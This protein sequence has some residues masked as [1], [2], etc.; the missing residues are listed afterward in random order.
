[1]MGKRGEITIFLSLVTVCCL[2]LFMGLLESART[3]GARL[4]LEMSVN[5]SMSSVMSQYNRNLWD[6]YHLLFLES[7]SEMAVKQSFEAFLEFYMKQENLYPM[8]LIETEMLDTVHM[9][10]HGGELLENEIAAYMRYRLPEVVTDMDV[11]AGAAREASRAGDFQQLFDVCLSAGTKTRKLE[12]SRIELE[13][14]LSGME[15]KLADAVEAAEE[16]ME[17]RLKNCLEEILDKAEQFPRL[18][19]AYE[20]ESERIS[21]YLE[22]LHKD[23]AAPDDVDA[24][25]KLNQ[26]IQ[27][28]AQVEGAAKEQLKQ[29]EEM[30]SQLESLKNQVKEILELLDA[31]TEHEEENGPDWSAIRGYLANM[32]IPEIVV[33]PK[34]EEKALAL[35]CLEELFS[36]GLSALVLPKNTEVSTKRVSMTGIPSREQGETDT[37]SR[38]LY[39][40]AYNHFV[41]NEYCLLSFDSFLE[42]KTT[43]PGREEQP[44]LYEM[45]YL[46][47]GKG[48]D[49]EN[50]TN[51]IQKLIFVRAAMN[52]CYLS[53]TPE[54]K[55]EADGFAAAISG[56]NIP[57]QVILSFFLL[58]L[59]SMGEAVLDVRALLAGGDVPFW[60]TMETW[61]LSL[62]QLV[63]LEFLNEVPYAGEK[64]TD[65]KIAGIEHDGTGMAVRENSFCDYE[66]YLRIL[67]FLLDREE[68]NFR[69]M[70]LLQWNVRVKQPDFLVSDCIGY[71]KMQ[72]KVRSR[73]L[74]FIKD[75]YEQTAEATGSY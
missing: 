73:H 64:N 32:S 56:G 41:V 31:E 35:D 70:D 6:I 54:K 7:E 60:K 63:S 71:I 45:E 36:G 28:F 34:S 43:E 59:W 15:N 40:T 13:K 68:K 17:E 2:S 52:L 11:V 12:K 39:E 74:F 18:V 10:D 42:E 20:Q 29:Y 44:L 30:K 33:R 46:V 48:S 62:D 24:A 49:R 1:M 9:V 75:E 23:A 67:C 16:E 38:P 53:G 55:A 8:K 58:T 69:I 50:L 65:D 57:I 47:S 72:V 4:Y 19:R 3:T 14:C 66:D 51:T 37:V 27:A 22:A 25:G 21:E 26:E 5:S 61:K